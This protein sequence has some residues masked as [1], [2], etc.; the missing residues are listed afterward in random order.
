MVMIFVHHTLKGKSH[1]ILQSS[2]LTR[3]TIAF[4]AGIK[5]AD[6][7]S[8]DSQGTTIPATDEE[9]KA[10]VMRSLQEL[11]ELEKAQLEARPPALHSS[12][13]E[14]TLVLGET[15]ETIE[16]TQRTDPP[17]EG[18]LQTYRDYLNDFPQLVA[19][20]GKERANAIQMEREAAVA[21]H[22]GPASAAVLA[23]LASEQM[24][25]KGKA[26]AKAKAKAKAKGKPEPKAKPKTR[27]DAAKRNEDDAEGKASKKRKKNA[28]DK[29]N[30]PPD[31]KDIKSPDGD[32]KKDEKKADV[33][34]VILSPEVKSGKDAASPPSSLSSPTDASSLHRLCT[35][36]SLGGLLNRKDTMVEDSECLD[37]DKL[38]EIAK[39][40]DEARGEDAEEP[41]K[42]IRNKA[43]HNRR[44]RFYR[45]LCSHWAW[46]FSAMCR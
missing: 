5:E 18:L 11:R 26:S 29:E 25:T 20:F 13:S 6:N 33:P 9:A 23:T 12:L 4:L 27:K 32:Q 15:E 36:E 45:S 42:R 24:K 1:I 19:T 31:D 40:E 44:M 14:R 2:I 34:C 30:T 46:S 16:P 21:Q 43:M 22:L 7:H 37:I 3:S 39:T 10:H 41:K 35:H 28:D 8:M 38:H 17:S